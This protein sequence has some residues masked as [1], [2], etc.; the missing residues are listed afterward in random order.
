MMLSLRSYMFSNGFGT[1]WTAKLKIWILHAESANSQ[2]CPERAARKMMYERADQ[3]GGMLKRSLA[4]L[5]SS[6]CLM[7]CSARA[8]NAHDTVTV[9]AAASLSDVLPEL[10]RAYTQQTGTR[11]EFSFAATS[12]LARQIEGGA[13]ADVFLA[14][15]PEWMDYLNQRGLIQRAT[16]R[17]LLGNRLALIAPADSTVQLQIGAGFP[18]RAALDGGRLATGDPD[19]VPAGRYA[20]AALSSLRVWNAVA[21]R[22]VRADNVRA[23]L[24]FV[25]RGEAPLGIVYETDALADKRVRIVDLFPASSYPPITYPVALT[26]GARVQAGSF[27]DFLHGPAA[28][29]V[30]KSRGFSVLH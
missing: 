1:R 16:R 5:L 12:M 25:A 21:D 28:A 22:L 13:R 4:G 9:F 18:L 29:A 11:V 8:T 24:A 15:D 3:G 30:F 2:N 20:R 7:S 27:L 14:A 10:A 6:L 17:N 26:S 23:A 19:S